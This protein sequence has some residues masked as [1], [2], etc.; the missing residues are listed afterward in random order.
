VTDT[1][2]DRIREFI[3][4]LDEEIEALKG[5]RGGNIV[6]VYNG[7]FQRESA[8]LHIYVFRLENP[9]VTMDDTPGDLEVKS[10]TY[11]CQIIAV[12]GMDI[13][14]AIEKH[15]GQYIE[16]GKI[17][18]N[19]WYLL[20]LLKKKYLEAPKKAEEEFALAEKLFQGLSASLDTNRQEPKYVAIK[21]P[22]NPSQEAA[23]CES[24][25]KSAAFIWGPPGTGK[26]VTIGLAAQA[27]LEAGRRVLVV[28]HANTAVDEALEKIADQ[29]QGSSLY[30]EGK[31]VRLG[32]HQKESLEQ[33]PM[34]LLGNIAETLGRPLIEEKQHLL[35]GRGELSHSLEKYSKI[36]SQIDTHDELESQ[37]EVLKKSLRDLKNQKDENE[38]ELDADEQT[39]ETRYET[40]AKAHDSGKLKKFFLGL[41]PE[42]IQEEIDG[43]RI[44]IDTKKR[45]REKIAA[46]LLKAEEVL[47]AKKGELQT[48]EI[49][50]QRG[51]DVL[52]STPDA[53]RSQVDTIGVKI[54]SIDSRIAEINRLLDDLQRGI[55]GDA[56][57]VATTLTKTFSSREFPD[58]EFDVVI[59]DESSMAPLPHLY[60]AVSRASSAVTIVGDFQQLPPICISRKALAQRWLKRSIFD[61]LGIDIQSVG[62]DDR[63]QLL[64][65]QY[66]M[67]PKIADIPNR[68]FYESRLANADR[69]RTCGFSDSISGDEPLTIIDTSDVNPWASQ[70]SSGGRFNIYSALVSVSIAHRVLKE[71]P[72]RRIGIVSPYRAQTKLIDKIAKDRGLDRKIRIGT[73]HSFQG[74]EESTIILD[75]VEGPGAKR[76]SMLNDR[77]NPDAPKLLN[78]AFTRARD[79]IYLVAHREHL[80]FSFGGNARLLQV[81]DVFDESGTVKRSKEITSKDSYVTESLGRWAGATMDEIAMHVEQEGTSYDERSFWPQFLSD[82]QSSQKGVIILSPFASSNRTGQ[83]MKYF[84]SLASRGVNIRVY[85]KPP[86]EQGGHLSEQAD[87]V[88][89]LLREWGVNVTQRKR[90]HQKIAIIDRRITW[91][92]SLNILSHRDTGERMR[93]MEGGNAAEEVIRDLELDE[94]EAA[95]DLTDEFCPE[96]LKKGIESPLVVKR[97]KFGTF[98]GCSA[99]PRC[100]YIE[101]SWRRPRAKR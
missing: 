50:I 54:D 63:V 69:V 13:H 95:G 80:S 27:H 91:E 92:G 24:F 33:Y 18:T 8:G 11:S 5:G 17:I 9:L 29:M 22:P 46:K 45:T 66:R 82:L 93:R 52:G 57:L 39:L 90:M 61:I 3:Q 89:N 30:E 48:L 31:L 55:L 75:C 40:L 38:V 42:R 32:V 53:V 59:S 98:K 88:V 101:K 10:R 78:V 12:Q 73:T 21:D 6:K 77:D 34:V 23:V 97:G 44:R 70:I 60:W 76:W 7:Q 25:W 81:I 100:R 14:I 43:L 86:S 74:G 84:V 62:S 85:M 71:H 83:L 49:E 67:H 20:E 51:L 4:A 99:F 16:E 87:R 65:K 96:C 94:A 15:L 56:R 64:N 2:T 47:Q 37:I 79:K 1:I 26:T 35:T 68:L 28:S 19:L 36:R 72:D 41:N 58:I